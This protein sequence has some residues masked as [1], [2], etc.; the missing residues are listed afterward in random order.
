MHGLGKSLLEVLRK[1][2]RAIHLKSPIGMSAEV[3]RVC[4]VTGGAQGIGFGIAKYVPCTHALDFC[5]F[6]H[7]L[8][9]CRHLG[10]LGSK[11]A[12][13]DMQEVRKHL[14]LLVCYM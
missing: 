12:V 3:A 4:L 5:C 7:E 8:A 6:L 1:A 11:V 14:N 13:M 2:K 10:T 9:V